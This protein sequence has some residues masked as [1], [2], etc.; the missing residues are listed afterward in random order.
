M[1]VLLTFAGLMPPDGWRAAADWTIS[2]VYGHDGRPWVR[3]E[4]WGTVVVTVVDLSRRYFWRN[5]WGDFRSEI[6]RHRPASRGE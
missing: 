1:L 6:Y 2:A 4:K 5:H 3:A